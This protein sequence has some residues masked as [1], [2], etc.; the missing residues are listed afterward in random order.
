MNR[1]PIELKSSSDW[2][3]FVPPLVAALVLC[4]GVACPLEAEVFERFVNLSGQPAPGEP[5]WVTHGDPQLTGTAVLTF[6]T[7]AGTLDFDIQL[8]DDR[9]IVTQAHI[10]EVGTDAQGDSDYC[11]GGRWS[12]HADFL[13]GTGL[14]VSAARINGARNNPEN[15]FLMVHTEGGH[16]ANGGSGL[17]PYNPA[18][19]ET[20]PYS[21]VTE[22]GS[23][24]NNRVGR[25]L[26][27]LLLREVN[28]VAGSFPNSTYPDPNHFLRENDQPF[29][30]ALGNVWLEPDGSGGW[31]LTSAA[32]GAGYDL[33]TEYLF[34]R[35]DD[36]GPDWD[37]GGPEGAAG[38]FLRDPFDLHGD[39]NLDG[40]VNTADWL[41][42]IA[43]YES[44]LSGLSPLEAFLAGDLNSDGVHS[45]ADIQLFRQDFIEA[46][47]N[48]AD[49][50][51]A[52]VPEPSTAV[53]VYASFLTLIGQ[54][55]QTAFLRRQPINAYEYF[56][57]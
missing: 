4:T 16:F 45:L 50:I 17:I 35:Y 40:I 13:Q 15:W 11:W 25:T 21:G 38:G 22:S 1:K 2:W 46:G 20:Q 12:G 19:H 32:I 44:D 57:K 9:Y 52:V 5:G 36:Q 27:N 55:R 30:D 51:S 47:G 53:I 3:Q 18:L 26:D 7:V 37:F 54:S 43:A 49:L 42:L 41:L 6:D 33:D 14:G 28:P 8:E 34:Y 23:R 24:F 48:P 56:S 29:A 10:Y 39:L 31:Q